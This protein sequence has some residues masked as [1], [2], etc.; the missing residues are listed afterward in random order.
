[1]DSKERAAAVAALNGR[2][3]LT[4]NRKRHLDAILASAGKQ[5]APDTATDS[6]AMEEMR[7][8]ETPPDYFVTR[9]GRLEVFNDRAVFFPSD[10]TPTVRASAPPP[11]PGATE[12][13]PAVNAEAETDDDAAVDGATGATVAVPATGPATAV[14]TALAPAEIQSIV[15]QAQSLSTNGLNAAQAQ[16]LTA[17]LSAPGQQFVQPGAAQ[18]SVLSAYAPAGGPAVIQ[19]SDGG[20]VTIAPTGNVTAMMTTPVMPTFTFQPL[21]LGLMLGTAIAS[22][23]LAIYLL[24]C[25]IMTLRQSPRA[26]RLHLIYSVIK[27]PVAIM[28]GLS[29]AWVARDLMASVVPGGAAGGT[30][31]YSLFS[32]AMP[33]VLGCAYPIALL[34]ALNVKSVREY[35]VGNADSTSLAAMSGDA[36][37][38]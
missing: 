26:R 36:I 9:A 14:A 12:A 3:S 32:G 2:H 20:S 23:A 8:G 5:I 34:I 38:S 19:F 11:E 25:G 28:A 7:S 35:Y 33:I 13:A 16:S 4:P 29:A 21:N 22:L 17:V 31:G 27:I 6:G 18:G 1:M 24:V 37:G 30:M 15:Q 10:G